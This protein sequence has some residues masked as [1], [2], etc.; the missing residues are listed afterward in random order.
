MQ[1]MSVD[2]HKYI[3]V[4]KHNHVKVHKHIYIN[5]EY[6]NAWQIVLHLQ[7]NINHIHKTNSNP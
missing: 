7:T 5:T 6:N 2:S 4:Y 1:D 3:Y